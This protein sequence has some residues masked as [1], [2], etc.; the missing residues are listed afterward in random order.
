MHHL[1]DN[2]DKNTHQ[3]SLSLTKLKY[4]SFGT[5]KNKN[6]KTR[7]TLRNSYKDQLYSKYKSSNV[8]PRLNQKHHIFYKYHKPSSSINKFKSFKKNLKKEPNTT[9]LYLEKNN[10]KISSQVNIFKY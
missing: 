1:K 10:S 2:L 6:S 7:I 4:S 5:Y 8:I 9:S 3:K